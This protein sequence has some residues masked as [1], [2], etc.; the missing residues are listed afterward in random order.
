M[1]PDW[2]QLDIKNEVFLQKCVRYTPVTFHLAHYVNFMR[3]QLTLLVYGTLETPHKCSQNY[4]T[5]FI[6]VYPINLTPPSRS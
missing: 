4:C 2:S 1:K 6:S 5:L 3:P